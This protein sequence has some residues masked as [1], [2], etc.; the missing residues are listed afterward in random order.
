MLS[1]AVFSISS[2]HKRKMK[3]TDIHLISFTE[4]ETETQRTVEDIVRIAVE[5]I[6]NILEGYKKNTG[7]A[8]FFKPYHKDLEFAKACSVKAQEGI[9]RLKQQNT[10]ENSKQGDMLADLEESLAILQDKW[11]PLLEEK[12][13][14]KQKKNRKI[15]IIIIVLHILLYG[16]IGLFILTKN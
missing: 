1:K 12:R 6:H 15:I 8:N 4:N 9:K 7:L 11:I 13:D 5:R 16:G 2:N 10:A 3:T 14:E